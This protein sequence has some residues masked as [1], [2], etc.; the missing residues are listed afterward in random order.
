MTSDA[1]DHLAIEIN[2]KGSKES[3]TYPKT[4][5]KKQNHAKNPDNT[6]TINQENEF[7]WFNLQLLVKSFECQLEG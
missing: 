3:R 4:E 7:K 5:K 2:K 6:Q 1:Q